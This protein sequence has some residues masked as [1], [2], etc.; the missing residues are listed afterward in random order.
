MLWTAGNSTRG[1]SRVQSPEA[2]TIS[3]GRGAIKAAISMLLVSSRRLAWFSQ[4]QP[5][6][7]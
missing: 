1:V 7:I 5:P 2:E 6:C 3:S 4:I